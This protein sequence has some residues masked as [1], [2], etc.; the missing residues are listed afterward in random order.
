MP[1]FD[2]VIGCGA[3]VVASRWLPKLRLGGDT[4][5]A[6]AVPVPLSATVGFTVASLVI[7]SVPL[8]APLAVGANAAEMLVLWP[9]ACTIGSVGWVAM[10]GG[11]A[12]TPLIVIA[13]V[14][15][16]FTVTD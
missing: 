3:L 6:G 9:I 16:F 2:T 12:D 14:P 7:E 13:D 15:V 1:V 5:I 4:A 8:A 10:N 11:V